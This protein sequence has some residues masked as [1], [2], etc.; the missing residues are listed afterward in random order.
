MISKRLRTEYQHWR[1][2][3]PTTRLLLISLVVFEMGIPIVYTFIN[4]FLLRYTNDFN[5]LVIYNTGWFIT[6]TATFY[7]NG[8]LVKQVPLT[9][10]QAFGAVSQA[11]VVLFLFTLT[12]FSWWQ[13]L[14]FGMLNGL[15]MG[16]YWANRNFLELEL[17][18]DDNRNYF[19]GLESLMVTISNIITPSIIAAI[20]ALALSTQ[21][22]SINQAYQIL[23]VLATI[24]M[25]VSG[26]LTLKLQV[27]SPNWNRLWIGAIK[28]P[29]NWGR[30][31][32][33]FYGFDNG[34]RLILPT[35]L[36]FT[37]IGTEVELGLLQTA[38]AVLMAGVAYWYARKARAT[39]RWRM[40]AMFLSI[41]ISAEVV[42]VLLPGTVSA[43]LYY[44]LMTVISSMGW[45][46]ML[47]MLQRQID[48]EDGGDQRN[49]YAYVADQEMFLNFGRLTGMLLFIALLAT[50]SD[51]NS[52]RL[53]ALSLVAVKLGMIT[54]AKQVWRSIR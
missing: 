34:A 12:H 15:P 35:L 17:T 41:L 51:L 10:V 38:S 52:L 5:S 19:R 54:A 44:S 7:F 4:A 20:M 36:I 33:F 45:M 39:H 21:L 13:L 18:S 24:V 46:T 1:K 14:G 43:L 26:F 30:L 50:V 16:L 6:V 3:Q 2:L 8:W 22:L 31:A 23:G 32:V 47:P 25:G 48:L 9:R 27:S 29:W 53:I 11:L 28:T 40:M 37:F 49:N 42:F